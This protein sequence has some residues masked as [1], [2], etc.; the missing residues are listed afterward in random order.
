MQGQL[1]QFNAYGNADKPPKF[2]EKGNLE[3][4][5]FTLQSKMRASDKV[6]YMNWLYVKNLLDKINLSSLL[7]G[8]TGKLI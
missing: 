3:V 5:L 7:L 4:L 6:P 1:S 2:M 8:L